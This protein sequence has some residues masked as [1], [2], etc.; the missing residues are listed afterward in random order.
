MEL[1]E[2]LKARR[3]VNFFDPAKDVD[4]K[5]IRDVFET[6]TLVPSSFNLQ[7]WKAI[8][9]HDQKN[10]DKLRAAAFNQ[11]KISDAPYVAILL[12]DKKAYEKMDPILDDMVTKGYMPEG[13]REGSKGM[14]K[15]LYGGDNER[16]FAGRNVGFFAMA[17]MLAA[18]SL[19]VDTHPMDGFDSGAVRKAFDIPEDYDIVMLLAF[20]H[21]DTTKTMM[22]AKMRYGFD[23]VV[24]KEGF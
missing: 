2:I 22:P 20:G 5:I 10:R 23:E 13:A 18:Q 15:G 3:A 24:V 8:L 7:P 16:A 17:L 12:G 19:G 6:A 21:F 14:A 9:L 11:P 1:K 4:E